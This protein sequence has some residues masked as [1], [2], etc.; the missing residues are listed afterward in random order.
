M[1]NLEYIVKRANT[2]IKRCGTRDPF[3]ICEAL[4]VNVKFTPLCPELKAYY[5]YQSRIRSVV[6]SSE[7]DEDTAR[8]VCAHELGHILLHAEMLKL[9][10][11]IYETS[12]CVLSD[13]TEYE[14]N[15]FASE[16][17]IDDGRLTELLA[18]ERKSISYTAAT[19]RVPEEI[20]DFKLQAM[21]S[22]GCG[23]APP[24]TARSDFL[25]KR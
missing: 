12:I 11:C 9:M 24:Y 17:L 2:V 19:L 21:Q 4:G 16:L 14:A 6:I 1:S 25:R 5:F 13:S 10:R 22:K 15:I 3:D 7:L 23:I 18:G 20:I 8:L